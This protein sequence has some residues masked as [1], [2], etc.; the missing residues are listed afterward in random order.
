MRDC[1]APSSAGLLLNVTVTLAI[2]PCVQVLPVFI[3]GFNRLAVNR[4]Q[5]V[6]CFHAHPVFVGW[7]IFVDV[8]D[9]IT[10]GSSVRLEFD[11]EMRRSN[12]ACTWSTW[13]ALRPCEKRSAHQSSR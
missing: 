10:A 9:A 2:E 3:T 6:A 7:S 4:E 1:Q 12:T 13:A 5:V 8:S 11:A